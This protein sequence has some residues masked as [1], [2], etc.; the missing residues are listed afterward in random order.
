MRQPPF[1]CLIQKEPPGLCLILRGGVADADPRGGADG[2]AEAVIGDPD[3]VR[4]H[5]VGPVLRSGDA[6]GT[7][8][9]SRPFCFQTGP[10]Q[11]P[12]GDPQRPR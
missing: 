9:L 6:Q 8:Q 10:D 7:G 4:G 1:L 3:L 5:G 2:A 11:N 12:P